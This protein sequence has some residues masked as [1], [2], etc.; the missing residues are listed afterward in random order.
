MINKK[1]IRLKQLV[2]NIN[3]EKFR[4]EK[5]VKKRVDAEKEIDKLN[6]KVDDVHAHIKKLKGQESDMVVVIADLKK[7]NVKRCDKLNTTNKDIKVINEKYAAK[8]D[9]VLKEFNIKKTEKEKVISVLDSKILLL[10]KKVNNL[11][12]EKDELLISNK[13]ISEK[14]NGLKN[15][16]TLINEE[17]NNKQEILEEHTVEIN[18]NKET[19]KKAKNTVSNLKDKEEKIEETIRSKTV[20]IESLN[21]E[22]KNTDSKLR[23]SEKE[24]E[25]I[26]NKKFAIAKDRKRIKEAIKDA[27][28]VYK[29]A[30]MEMPEIL[31]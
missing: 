22:I 7:E 17:I 31:L 23:K 9:V 13:D 25:A 24:F 12:K 15:E 26:E 1:K 27:K 30:G 8:E 18:N 14:N 11:N 16:K 3:A 2:N 6:N 19:I 21:K 4:L 10:E 20:E 28:E 5:L 29:K